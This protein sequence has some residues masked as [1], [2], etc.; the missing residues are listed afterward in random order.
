MTQHLGW[1]SLFF[2]NVPLG[3]LIL[4]LISLKLKDQEWI[5]FPG[6]RFDWPGALI[7]GAGLVMTMYG[8]S[9]LPDFPSSVLVLAGLVALAGFLVRELRIESPLLDIRLFRANR[10]FTLSNLAAFINYSATAGIGL[11]LSLYLQYNKLLSAQQAGLVLVAQPVMQAVFSPLAGRLSD[12]IQPRIVASIGMGLT[13]LGLLALAFIG[14]Q[15]ALPVIVL[16]LLLH[17]LAFALFSSPNTNAVMSAVD[18]RFYGV[19][20]GTLATMRSTGQMFSLGVALLMFSRFIGH[21]KITPDN[22]ERFLASAR[23]SFAIFAA[24]C[25]LGVFASLARGRRVVEQQ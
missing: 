5:E 21:A 13:T 11:L 19:A 6:A 25:L 1:R 18:R 8:F 23:W 20:A 9:T 16:V 12:R 14:R 10:A 15:T 2:V 3:I 17:G 22:A 24:L 4:V 7:Y